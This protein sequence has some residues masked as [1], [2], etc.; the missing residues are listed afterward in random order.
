MAILPKK[1]FYHLLP[2]VSVISSLVPTFGFSTK[3]PSSGFAR[4]SARHITWI[5][6]SSDH[7]ETIVSVCDFMVWFALC[8]GVGV[9]LKTKD[10]QTNPYSLIWPMYLIYM[11]SHGRQ[12]FKKIWGP[13]FLSTGV[14]VNGVLHGLVSH[15]WTEWEATWMEQHPGRGCS[16]RL[17]VSGQIPSKLP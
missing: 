12:T 1:T 5:H 7:T 8:Q 9:C 6:P 10:V 13:L 3:S 14:P 16:C 11:H 15:A 17:I 2:L 4:H